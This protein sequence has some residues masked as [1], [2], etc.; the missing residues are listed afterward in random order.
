M[1][2]SSKISS[3]FRFAIGGLLLAALLLGNAKRSQ[4]QHLP[5]E[6]QL[7][8][9]SPSA[10]GAE[11]AATLDQSLARAMDR[12][13]GII[14]ARAKV[15]LAQAQLNSTRLEVARQLV[16]L[17]SD[18]QVQESAVKLARS[19]LERDEQLNKQAAVTTEELENAKGALVDAEAKLAR[20]QMELRYLTGQVN[21]MPAAAAM[22]AAAR[23]A[24]VQTPRGPIVEKIY[25]ALD[26]K[27]TADLVGTPLE[28][29]VEFLGAHA[30]I[31]IILDQHALPVAGV[32]TLKLEGATIAA[33]L[34]AMED[35][36]RGGQFVVRE[37]GLLF[38]D[39]GYAVEQGLLPVADFVKAKAGSSAEP[40]APSKP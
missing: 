8:V 37:Y 13:P 27:V 26:A 22:E 20:T 35:Q 19:R 25:Q 3:S 36:N 33:A 23:S 1:S 28:D 39:R 15:A 18:R 21:L 6:R 16:A 29:A 11:P 24:T 7:P 30:K 14:A 17:W 32:V 31:P 5:I 38:T 2:L 12:N 34:Q 9:S 40:A 4:G 10:K